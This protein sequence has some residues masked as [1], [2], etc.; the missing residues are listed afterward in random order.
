MEKPNISFQYLH[1][2]EGNYKIFGEVIFR[3]PENL[4]IEG[5][6]ENFRRKL[7][8]SEFFYPSDLGIPLFPE[9]KGII[10]FSDWY[11]FTGFVRTFKKSTDQR[12]FKNFLDDVRT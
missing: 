10:L 12:S 2:D 4:E 8:D 6:E 9:H 5:A 11:E 7:I 3:N 1:R